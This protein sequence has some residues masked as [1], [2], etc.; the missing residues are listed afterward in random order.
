MCGFKLIYKQVESYSK[1]N[2]FFF[3]TMS[4][5]KNSD[6][7]VVIN[8]INNTSNCGRTRAISCFYFSTLYATTLHDKLIKVLFQIIDF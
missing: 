3:V 2:T 8:S 7:Q 5:E 1:Q 6:N 4:Y